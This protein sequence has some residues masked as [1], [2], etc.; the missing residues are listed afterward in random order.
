MGCLY[1]L[2]S[3]YIRYGD[4][5]DN[6]VEKYPSVFSQSKCGQQGHAGSIICS[7][8]VSYVVPDNEVTADT[9]YII[10]YPSQSA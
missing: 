5:V 3:E 7:V 2:L 8:S 4:S 10:K 1:L 9:V 6:T